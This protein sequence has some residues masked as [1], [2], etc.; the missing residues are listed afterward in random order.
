MT[1]QSARTLDMLDRARAKHRRAETKARE[2]HE[3]F[4]ICLRSWQETSGADRAAERICLLWA[5]EDMRDAR[6]AVLEACWSMQGVHAAVEAVR[7][8]RM[9]R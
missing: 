5:I 2:A 3:Y 8:G 6:E 9:G 1:S 7:A 4:L